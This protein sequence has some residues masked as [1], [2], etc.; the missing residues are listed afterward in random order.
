MSEQTLALI[1]AIIVIEWKQFSRVNNSGGKAQCQNNPTLF[2]AM[3]AIQASIWQERTLSS[4]LNDLRQAEAANINLMTAKYAYMMAETHPSEYQQIAHRLPLIS[5]EKQRLVDLIITVF[6]Q[7]QTEA[8]QMLASQS[9]IDFQPASA[10]TYLRG[11]L[12]TWSEKTLELCLA[13]VQQA[14]SQGRNLAK[15]ILTATLDYY[16]K[17]PNAKEAAPRQRQTAVPTC[18]CS[19]GETLIS[20]LAEL[21]NLNQRLMGGWVG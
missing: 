19:G 21:K 15:E 4:Y 8:G 18:P 1:K 20:D 10:L 3:R 12:L 7:W 17:H 9:R 14:R 16:E 2:C 5:V 13:D 11:E 6:T